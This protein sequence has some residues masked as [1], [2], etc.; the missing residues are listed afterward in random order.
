M[1]LEW[2][3]VDEGP[4]PYEDAALDPPLADDPA[5]LDAVDGVD[6]PEAA[7]RT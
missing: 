3:P 2:I 5:P 6:P 1:P 4:A 7:S